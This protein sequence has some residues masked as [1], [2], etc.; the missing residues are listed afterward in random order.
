[1]ASRLGTVA[2]NGLVL[3]TASYPGDDWQPPSPTT[4]VPPPPEPE[5]VRRRRI[6]LSLRR[7]PIV[8]AAVVCTM[9]CSLVARPA[10]AD[11]GDSVPDTGS[12]PIASGTLI[13][14]GQ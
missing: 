7:G 12:R 10:Y 13:I 3:R 9:L 4:F 1:M 2:M 11:P 6:R 5:Q 14:P 8:A